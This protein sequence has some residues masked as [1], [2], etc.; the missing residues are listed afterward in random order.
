MHLTP[1]SVTRALLALASGPL[2]PGYAGTLDAL[3]RATA[4]LT[5][6]PGLG[7]GTVGHVLN[8]AAVVVDAAGLPVHATDPTGV[9]ILP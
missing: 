3:G 4:S 2:A 5:V 9:L 7:P 6:P 8:H 1:D